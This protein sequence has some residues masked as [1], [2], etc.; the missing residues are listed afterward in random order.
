MTETCISFCP[1]ADSLV[2]ESADMKHA[3]T[4]N[5]ILATVHSIRVRGSVINM[6][7]SSVVSDTGENDLTVPADDFNG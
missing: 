7:F 4:R 1:G 2:H 5:V 6:W 3:A